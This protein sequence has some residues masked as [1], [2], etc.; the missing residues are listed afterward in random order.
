MD[1]GGRKE[2]IL[3]MVSVL[4][5]SWKGLGLPRQL[6]NPIGGPRGRP[7]CEGITLPSPGC[8]KNH[9]MLVAHQVYFLASWIDRVIF[10]SRFWEVWDVPLII[11]TRADSCSVPPLS[12]SRQP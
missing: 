12:L 11:R 6:P 10:E 1:E 8:K 4:L 2:E 9:L 3:T 5:T 7:E